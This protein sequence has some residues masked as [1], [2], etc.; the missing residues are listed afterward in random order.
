MVIDT[1]THVFSPRVVSHREEY[2]RRDPCFAL[3]YSNPKAQLVTVRELLVSMDYCEIDVSVIAGIG[4]TSQE[5]CAENN[6]YLLECLARYPH[7]LVG[8]ASI[9]PRAGDA[10][11]KELERCVQGGVKGVGE[12]RADI[13]GFDLAS[14]ILSEVAAFLIEHKLVWLSHASEPV[15]HCYPGK[16]VLTPEVLYPFVLRYPMLKI[17][18]AHWGGGLPF[19]AAMPEVRKALNNIY[20]DTAASS[21]LYD[22]IVY[23]QVVDTMGA[24][25]VLFGSDYPLMS[26]ARALAE[27][28]ASGL[29]ESEQVAI[30]SENARGLFSL[31]TDTQ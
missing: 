26:P 17:I 5:L 9:Q 22:P 8:L 18:L 28:R 14:G 2:V 21:Y 25:H 30:T 15:G 24:E 13:Q 19:Y 27:I 23:R 11:M 31:D 10:A 29:T 3:L 6:D 20:F 4:W 16:G 12:M 1:H 7:R